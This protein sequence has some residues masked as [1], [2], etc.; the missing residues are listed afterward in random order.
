SQRADLDYT[1]D[2]FEVYR[3]LR[4]INPSPYMY[5]VRL[6]DAAGNEFSVVGSS[7]ETLVKV[8]DREVTTF[9]IAG[10][11]PRGATVEEDHKLVE[12]LL[13]DPKELSEHLMLVDLS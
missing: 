13:A 1:G 8:Q 6:A 12:E 3:V 10:S 11:R 9:P 5:Y 7:P 2:P 4:T